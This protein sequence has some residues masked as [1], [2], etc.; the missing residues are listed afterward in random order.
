MVAVL[1]SYKDLLGVWLVF[2][3]HHPVVS[4]IIVPLNL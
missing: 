1:L 3:L 2:V 4:E